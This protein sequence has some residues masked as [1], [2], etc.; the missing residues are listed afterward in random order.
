M[1]IRT[2]ILPRIKNLPKIL[3]LEIART[4]LDDLKIDKMGHLVLIVGDR[5]LELVPITVD[6]DFR[7]PDGKQ[8]DQIS[9]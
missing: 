3:G 2:K 5:Q 4:L 9:L 7:P 6:I 1:K 8:G